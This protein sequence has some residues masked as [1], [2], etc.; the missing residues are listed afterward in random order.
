MEKKMET[1]TLFST[2]FK[3]PSSVILQVEAFSPPA[4]F[5]FFR[6]ASLPTSLSSP[7]S[8]LYL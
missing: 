1:T 7:L 2:V 6:F 3:A 4:L 8:P 5:P